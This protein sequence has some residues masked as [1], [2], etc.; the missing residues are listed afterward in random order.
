MLFT[1][2]FFEESNEINGKGVEMLATR[3]GR[4][5]NEKYGLP[6]RTLE[7][8]N[9]DKGHVYR[10]Y[11]IPY[12]KGEEEPRYKFIK[13]LLDDNK[14]LGKE[15]RDNL[16]NKSKITR[17]RLLYGNFEY[18]DSPGKMFQYDPL[19]DLKTNPIA[20]TGKKYI[21]CD[22]ARKG[23]DRAVIAVW[24]GFKIIDSF[25]FKKCGLDEI[26]KKILEFAEKYHIPMRQVIVDEDGL[27][28]R[29]H[30]SPKV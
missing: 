1:D 16:L 18:D 27:G 7:T 15:Y 13:A 17:E 11:W 23:R 25:T 10:R 26:E 5:K 4:W 20:G 14:Y 6:G 8:F 29:D 12:K 24:D 21:T 19:H 28:G 30:R 2:G 3:V 22:P 9:P